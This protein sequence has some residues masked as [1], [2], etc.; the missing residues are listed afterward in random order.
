MANRRN[1]ASC[2]TWFS[3]NKGIPLEDATEGVPCIDT[4]HE[5]IHKGG[6][7]SGFKQVSLGASASYVLGFANGSTKYIHYRMAK[8]STNQ[9]QITIE[10]RKDTGF[11]GGT[12]IETFNHNTVITATATMTVWG[13]PTVTA[14]GTLINQDVI[15]GSTGI[16]GTR[17]G[18][19]S[20]GSAEEWVFAPN[21]KFTGTLVNGTTAVATVQVGFKWY[22][23][24]GY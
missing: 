12:A 23:E 4:D 24:D 19:E 7:F 1:T 14:T 16:G 13:A 8:I 20:S 18:G 6:F 2:R 21:A 10:L 5:Y 9:P 3:G 15:W 11:N 17:V 22:E